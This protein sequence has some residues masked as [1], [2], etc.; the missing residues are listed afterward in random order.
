M[1]KVPT[2]QIAMADP[3]QL[4]KLNLG[5]G[6]WKA[7]FYGGKSLENYG[8]GKGTKILSSSI[9]LPSLD[10]DRIISKQLGRRKEFGS[11]IRG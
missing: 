7:R 3:K 1:C 9:C 8:L 5:N 6:S 4:F 11:L 2:P 10:D